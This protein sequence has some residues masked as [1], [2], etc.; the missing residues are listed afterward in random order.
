MKTIIKLLLGFI[1]TIIFSFIVF[2]NRIIKERLPKEIQYESI[3]T[4]DTIFLYLIFVLEI[5]ILFYFLFKYLNKGLTRSTIIS[6]LFNKVWFNNVLLFFKEY[7]IEGPHNIYKY[8]Y[9]SLYMRPV[10]NYIGAKLSYYFTGKEFIPYIIGFA[11]PRL[12]LWVVLF[13][14]III[15]QKINYFYKTLI[16]LLV[17]VI[18]SIILYIIKHHA[19][20]SI[21][22]YEELF[23]FD[24][25]EETGATRA[26][27]K[28]LEDPLKNVNA[29]NFMH[30]LWKTIGIFFSIYI[31]FLFKLRT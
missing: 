2:W 17:P 27:Y 22:F 12:I 28:V 6:N 25:N 7:I 9:K 16:L 23:N 21:A 8:A 31:I 24:V 30:N 14:E 13:C 26:S 4:I 10:I 18:F 3:M 11:L 15:M 29:K 5:S 1:T 19:M 20:E